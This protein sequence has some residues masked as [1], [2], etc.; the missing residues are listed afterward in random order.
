MN[1]TVSTLY[2]L[3]GVKEQLSLFMHTKLPN[4]S[5][6]LR[7]YES[8]I[9]NFVAITFNQYCQDNYKICCSYIG[10]VSARFVLNKTT[11]PTLITLIILFSIILFKLTKLLFLNMITR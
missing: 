10:G 1:H 8:D 11:R 3:Y 7:I 6:Q 4:I 5:L 2:V 9:L